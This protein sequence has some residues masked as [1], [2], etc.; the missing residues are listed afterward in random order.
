MFDGWR[1]RKVRADQ[2]PA[3]LGLGDSVIFYRGHKLT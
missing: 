1:G 3:N 2:P